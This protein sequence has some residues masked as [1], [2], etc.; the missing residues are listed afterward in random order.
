[1]LGSGGFEGVGFTSRTFGLEGRV[2]GASPV[3]SGARDLAFEC[4][5]D[6]ANRLTAVDEHGGVSG[7]SD[8]F[9]VPG[10]AFAR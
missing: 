3:A 2:V 7:M 6:A 10:V 4:V 8:C 9:G 5:G 1:M